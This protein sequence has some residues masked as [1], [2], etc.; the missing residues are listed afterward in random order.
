MS[1]AVAREMAEGARRAGKTDFAIAVTGIAGPTGGTEEK[2][3]GTVFIALASA[4]ETKVR[5]LF[6]PWD[7]PTFKQMTAEQ[8]L[9]FLRRLLEH[10]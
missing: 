6:N 4:H 9:N 5:K 1:E 3:A 7:R 10:Q 8:A 2:P